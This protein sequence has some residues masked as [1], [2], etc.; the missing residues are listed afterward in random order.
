[1]QIFPSTIAAFVDK[2]TGII[3]TPWIQY[4]QQFTQAPPK[5]I[6]VNVGI[7]PFSYQAKEP[8]Y[9]SIVG[10]VNVGSDLTTNFNKLSPAPTINVASNATIAQLQITPASGTATLWTIKASVKRS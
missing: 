4:L 10:G 6:P 9:V 5:F 8:G 3:K 1:M 2:A 7:S